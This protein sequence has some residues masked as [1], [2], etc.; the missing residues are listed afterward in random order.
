MILCIFWAA[1]IWLEH[2]TDDPPRHKTG[3]ARRL[4]NTGSGFPRSLSLHLELISPCAAQTITVCT[5]A[6]CGWLCPRALELAGLICPARYWGQCLNKAVE[7]VVAVEP[8]LGQGTFSCP[9]LPVYRA[10]CCKQSYKYSCAHWMLEVRA[11]QH[12]NSFWLWK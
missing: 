1:S 5:R 10:E 6:V 9:C 11:D 8:T 2:R 4:R 3:L 12:S 7:L